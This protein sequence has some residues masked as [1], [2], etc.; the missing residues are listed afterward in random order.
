MVYIEEVRDSWSE[1]EAERSTLP[2][3]ALDNEDSR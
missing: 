2:V 3:K 1:K